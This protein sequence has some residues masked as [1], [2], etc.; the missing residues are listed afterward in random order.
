MHATGSISST[1]SFLWRSHQWQSTANSFSVSCPFFSFSFFLWRQLKLCQPTSFCNETVLFS[2]QSY[3]SFYARVQYFLLLLCLFLFF[4]FGA[5]RNHVKQTHGANWN[6]VNQTHSVRDWFVL[7]TPL[8]LLLCQSTVNVYIFLVEGQT[9]I[10]SLPLCVRWY[11][12]LGSGGGGGGYFCLFVC[13]GVF[14][15]CFF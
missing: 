7:Q 2:R 12:T 5:N 10:N 9:C 14:C 11:G 1:C 4:V 6:Y 8:Q 3:S 13:W 15:C